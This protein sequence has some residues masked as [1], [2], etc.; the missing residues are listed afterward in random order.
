VKLFSEIPGLPAHSFPMEQGLQ[1]SIQPA[2][3]PA[4]PPPADLATSSVDFSPSV[5]QE[6]ASLKDE[7][8]KREFGLEIVLLKRTKDGQER[9][10]YERLQS[11]N[12]IKIITLGT[13]GTGPSPHRNGKWTCFIS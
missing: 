4:I 7:A 3:R 10:R 1:I 13:S 8:S 5:L 11:S 12:A 6:Y 2:I 9:S